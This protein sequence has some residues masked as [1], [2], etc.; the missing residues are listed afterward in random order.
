[1]NVYEVFQVVSAFLFWSDIFP[2]LKTCKF[3][4]TDNKML[5]GN[6]ATM[7]EEKKKFNII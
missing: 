2:V 7:V 3:K 4:E 6:I 1:M 5:H